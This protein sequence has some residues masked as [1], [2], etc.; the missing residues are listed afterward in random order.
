MAPQSHSSQQRQNSS[1]PHRNVGRTKR[2]K[3]CR[4]DDD[5][6]RRNIIT[7]RAHDDG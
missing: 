3:K 4:R 7:A 2:Q 5:E 1:Q 6:S